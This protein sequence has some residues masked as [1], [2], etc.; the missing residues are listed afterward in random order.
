MQPIGHPCYCSLIFIIIW[1]VVRKLG[2]AF[3][4]YVVTR[5][6]LSTP[7]GFL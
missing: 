1:Y 6:F 5:T 7:H 4:S 3:D 2:G